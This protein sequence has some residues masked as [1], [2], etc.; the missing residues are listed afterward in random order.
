MF[1]PRQFDGPPDETC[2]NYPC[3][4]Y[5]ERAGHPA[6]LRAAVRDGHRAGER[7]LAVRSLPRVPQQH[8]LSVR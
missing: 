7:G 2:Y 8:E 6:A 1:L 3:W 5:T 4:L